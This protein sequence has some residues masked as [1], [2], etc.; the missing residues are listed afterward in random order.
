M[1]LLGTPNSQK[2]PTPPAPPPNP[3]NDKFWASWVHVASPHCLIGISTP[4]CVSH[5]FLA[6]GQGCNFLVVIQFYQT[7]F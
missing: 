1:E 2:N 7:F 5:H 6:Y 4:N 3:P